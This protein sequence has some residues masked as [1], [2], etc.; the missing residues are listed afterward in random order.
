MFRFIKI[1]RLL[2]VCLFVCLFV[3]IERHMSID[4]MSEINPQGEISPRPR[5]EVPIIG[6]LVRWSP[7]QANWAFTIL[8]KDLLVLL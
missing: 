2:F 3:S 1:S 5:I 6:L 4:K 8:K 7:H